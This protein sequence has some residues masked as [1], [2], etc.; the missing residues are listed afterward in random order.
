MI[1]V[2]QNML[3][4]VESWQDVINYELIR[5]NAAWRFGLVLLGI[6]VTMVTGR[7]VQFA[8]GEFVRK[9]KEKTGETVATLFFNALS[10]P[11]YVAVFALGL[12]LCKLFL[13]FNDEDGIRNIILDGWTKQY[14]DDKGQIMLYEPVGC[15]SCSDS[16]YKGRLGLHELLIA[17]DTIKKNIQEHARVAEMLVTALGEGMRTLKQDG[18]E[19]VLEGITDMKQVRTVCIK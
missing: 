3:A 8:V 6:L 16:G 5:G 17:T 2:I 12:N 14:G 19:K 10:K 9:R 1:A 4:A 13:Y 7:I 15:D 18:M 11:I